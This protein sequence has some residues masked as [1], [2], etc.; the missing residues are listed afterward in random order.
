[1]VVPGFLAD[2]E[3]RRWLNGIEPAWTALDF[4]SFNSL[5]HEPSAMNEA[6]RLEP[7][8]AQTELLGSA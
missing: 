5:H 7:N 1:M 3:V 2:P 4:D 8:L 6:I